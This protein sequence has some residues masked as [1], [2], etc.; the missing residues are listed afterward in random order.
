MGKRPTKELAELLAEA[1]SHRD[2]R[3]ELSMS[4]SSRVRSCFGLEVGAGNCFFFFARNIFLTPETDQERS[5]MR[6]SDKE[7]G[8][9]L[10]ELNHTKKRSQRRNRKLSFIPDSKLLADVQFFMSL[11][12]HV[13]SFKIYICSLFHL[14]FFPV[15]HGETILKIPYIFHIKKAHASFRGSSLHKI[16]HGV[17]EENPSSVAMRR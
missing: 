10:L 9:A 7:F 3:H 17:A 13:S 16:T 8:M 12:Q 6:A 4:H 2:Q 5:A 11:C 15:M 14:F 1:K